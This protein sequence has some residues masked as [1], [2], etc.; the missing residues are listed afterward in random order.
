MAEVRV[1]KTGNP[2]SHVLAS[3]HR[4]SWRTCGAIKGPAAPTRFPLNLILAFP[5]AFFDQN[6]PA[7]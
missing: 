6:S 1:H 4:W 5:H 7:V 2:L 3:E